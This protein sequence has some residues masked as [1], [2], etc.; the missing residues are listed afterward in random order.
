MLSQDKVGP[1][2]MPPRLMGF[3]GGDDRSGR[4]CFPGWV[5]VADYWG[6][7]DT[8]GAMKLEQF[9]HHDVPGYE[10]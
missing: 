3:P 6:R 4:F 7:R 10:W 1:T 9:Y 2:E 5:V 8:G